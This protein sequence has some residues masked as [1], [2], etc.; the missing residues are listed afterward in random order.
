MTMSFWM[1]ESLS[2]ASTKTRLRQGGYGLSTPRPFRL[3]LLITVSPRHWK[4]RNTS[5]SNDTKR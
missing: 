3:L 5:S 4:R 2:V 1:G